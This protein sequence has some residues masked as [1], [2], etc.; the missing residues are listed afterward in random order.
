MNH[1]LFMYEMAKLKIA[2]DLRWAEQERL[3][4]LARAAEPL[5]PIDAVPF[6]ERLTRLFGTVWPP[7]RGGA[8][9]GA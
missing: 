3:A 8:T 4:R 6:R 9:A 2:E 5:G 1:P 7:A